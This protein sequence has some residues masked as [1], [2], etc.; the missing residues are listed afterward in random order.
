[1]NNSV[2]NHSNAFNLIVNQQMQAD[3]NKRAE[4]DLKRKLTELEKDFEEE[5]ESMYA[6][7]FAT[8]K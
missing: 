5:K 1:M 3:S 2:Y 7:K 4:M 8:S 6:I